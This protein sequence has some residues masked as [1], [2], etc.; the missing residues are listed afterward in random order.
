M[1]KTYPTLP[2]GPVICPN[3]TESGNPIEMERDNLDV[4]YLAEQAPERGTEF[5]S[6][7]CPDCE[8]VAVFRVR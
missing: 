5:Q 4:D 2:A 3:C 1:A 8:Y 6:Y 7:R